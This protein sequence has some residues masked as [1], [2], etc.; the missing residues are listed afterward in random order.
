MF[1]HF[2]TE[3]DAYAACPGPRLL[4]DLVLT[5]MVTEWPCLMLMISELVSS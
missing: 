1:G 4:S 5:I 2:Y 3:D